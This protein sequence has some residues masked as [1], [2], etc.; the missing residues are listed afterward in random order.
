[1]GGEEGGHETD[2]YFGRRG[3]EGVGGAWRAGRVSGGERGTVG[4]PWSVVIDA[5]VDSAR[6][7]ARIG[8]ISFFV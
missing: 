6:A 8:T 5:V 4:S 2:G 7:P 3:G 1:M